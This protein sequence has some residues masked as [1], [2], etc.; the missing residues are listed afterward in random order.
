[1]MEK[2]VVFPAPLGPKRP[3]TSPLLTERLTPSTT[4]RRAKAFFKFL[5]MSP[6]VV[7]SLWAKDSVM[8]VWI[9]SPYQLSEFN[10]LVMGKLQKFRTRMIDRE[11]LSYG[12]RNQTIFAF[13]TLLIKMCHY[14]FV[15]RWQWV[16][17]INKL[18]EMASIIF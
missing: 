6:S 15:T 11:D 4:V 2:H 8:S 14:F 18:R 13:F 3:T 5:A 1:M 10:L 9:L 7:A 17:I 16:M 12:E